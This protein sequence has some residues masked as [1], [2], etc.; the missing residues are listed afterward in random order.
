MTLHDHDEL[1]HAPESPDARWQENLFFILWD[2]ATRH[3]FMVHLQRIPALG[4]QEAQAVVSI[5]G[6]LGRPRCAG[7]SSPMPVWPR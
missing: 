7:P 3:G 5:G 4:W 6:T 2:T 1:F